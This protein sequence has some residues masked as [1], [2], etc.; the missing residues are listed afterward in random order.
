MTELRKQ[1]EDIDRKISD[2]Q[3]MLEKT[4]D[5]LANA[6]AKL[7]GL[8]QEHTRMTKIVDDDIDREA[9]E[10][11]SNIVTTYY[12]MMVASLQPVIP[13]L[14]NEQREVLRESG[15]HDLT[16]NP[17]HV[18]N[19]ALFLAIN[20][21]KE[22]TTYAESCG[23]S[24]GNMKGWGR[25]KNDDDERWWMRCFARAAAMV[26]PSVRKKYLKVGR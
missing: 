10:I 12:K 1:M 9:K 7:D 4:E 5:V 6:K 8:R 15:F 24:G 19:F 16:D 26:K 11:H 23:G 14:T 25:D 2:K 21:I 17:Q 20:F 22:A 13:T 3:R 18:I